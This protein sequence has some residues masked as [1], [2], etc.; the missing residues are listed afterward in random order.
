M[1]TINDLLVYGMISGWNTYEKLSYLYCMENKKAFTFI[2]GGKAC[3]F[4]SHW[5][6]LPSYHWYRN[7][8]NNFLKSKVEKDVVFLV[9]SGKELYDIVSQYEDIVFGFHYDK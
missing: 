1:W 3:F 5:R 7:N 6:F 8:K 9:L 4:Y 2:N